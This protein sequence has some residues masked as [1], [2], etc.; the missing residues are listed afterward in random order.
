MDSPRDRI[1]SLNA[2]YAWTDD[3]SGLLLKVASGRELL[4]LVELAGL[5]FPERREH[6]L[7]LALA[8]AK[9]AAL[10]LT[11]AG[12]QKALEE[13]RAKSRAAEAEPDR[14]RGESAVVRRRSHRALPDDTLRPDPGGQRRPGPDPRL[15]GPCRPQDRQCL[16]PS[17]QPRRP[18]GLAV[19][20]R[21]EQFRR[22]LRDAAPAPRRDGHL[23]PRFL[24]RHQ[25]QAGPGRLL[26]GV[27]RGHHQEEADR[28]GQLLEPPDEDLAGRCLRTPPAADARSRRCPPSSSSTPAA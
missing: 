20:A 28:R 15:P 22:D 14:Q 27:D 24:A 2:D 12:V 6:D 13:E 11:K 19:P 26:R 23:G 7:N 25:G 5:P 8:L 21:G 18:R 4:G 3:R 16:G 17:P 9:I 10:A 1:L